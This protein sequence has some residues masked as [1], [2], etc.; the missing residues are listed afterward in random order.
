ME[1]VSF[2]R[3]LDKLIGSKM[4]I[5][6]VLTDGHLEIAALMSKWVFITW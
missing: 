2:E 3:G 5:K 1:R 4:I 6:E